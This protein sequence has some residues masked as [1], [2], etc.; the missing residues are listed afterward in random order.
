MI[1]ENVYI[2]VT[3][4]QLEMALSFLHD[5]GYCWRNNPYSHK[6]LLEYKKDIYYLIIKSDKY[7]TWIY[8]G[9]KLND[10]F[11]I[12]KHINFT[13]LLRKHKLKRILK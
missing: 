7:I 3:K 10:I 1:F 13:I 9:E 6:N 12:Y 4:E 5:N 2:E 11:N 8:K